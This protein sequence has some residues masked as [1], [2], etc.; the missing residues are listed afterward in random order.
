[1]VSDICVDEVERAPFPQLKMPCSITTRGMKISY[2][3][4]LAGINCYTLF[5]MELL[6]GGV[7]LYGYG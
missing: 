6:K 2:V 7:I 1:M 5:V 3:C 4:L